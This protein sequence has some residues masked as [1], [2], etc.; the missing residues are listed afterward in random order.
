[1]QWMLT[2]LCAVPAECNALYLGTVSTETLTGAPAVQKATSCTLELDP[3]P[4]PTLVRLRAS[5]QGVTLTD[6]QRRWQKYCKSSRIFGF[7]AKSQTESENLCH[8]FAE[9]DPVQPAALVIDLITKL[10]PAP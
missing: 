2:L 5:E 1:M 8:L 7:V 6:V 9:Y 4:T 10:L 3:L